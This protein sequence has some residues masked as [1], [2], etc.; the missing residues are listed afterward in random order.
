MHELAVK[1][2]IEIETSCF[3]G[4]NL[5]ETTKAKKKRPKQKCTQ[6]VLEHGVEQ[7]GL[8]SNELHDGA[9]RR[10]RGGAR[11]AQQ[12]V[13]VSAERRDLASVL[14]GCR[15]NSPMNDERDLQGS[16]SNAQSRSI[17]SEFRGMPTANAEG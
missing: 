17:F 5:E 8:R 12:R 4:M 11:A 1:N 3:D 6:P 15:E 14:S 7:G 10:A 2:E 9:R 13:E 16:Q